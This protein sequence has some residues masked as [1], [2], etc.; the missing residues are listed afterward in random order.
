MLGAN[1]GE[2]GKNMAG[3]L[4]KLMGMDVK[5]SVQVVIACLVLMVMGVTFS[6]SFFLSGCS[7]WSCREK[8]KGLS[9][10]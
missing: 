10:V 9:V 7:V 4:L 6:V 5:A 8:K 1:V 2:A 3:D